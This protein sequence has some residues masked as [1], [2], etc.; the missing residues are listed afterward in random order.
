[1]AREAA[2]RERVRGVGLVH[3]DARPLAYHLLGREPEV[4][5][6]RV[7]FTAV[8]Q[9]EVSAQSSAVSLYQL[10]A[11]PYR[12]GLADV[13]SEAEKLLTGL[14]GLELV[15]LSPSLAGQAARVRA[16]LGTDAPASAQIATA[17]DEEAELFLTDG[18]S[19][20]R[21]AGVR[22]ENLGDYL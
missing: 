9:E 14:R 3:V 6:T 7:L 13:A 1:M 5:L 4:V 10:L 12:R 11:E 20:R 16:R 2:F 22:V 15:P 19:L 21:V 17:V 18:S 8:R